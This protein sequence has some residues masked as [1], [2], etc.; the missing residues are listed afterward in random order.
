[1]DG[2]RRKNPDRPREAQHRAWSRE[3]IQRARR[4]SL[5]PILKKRGYPL[6]EKTDDNFLVTDH[7]DLVVKDFYWIW[8]SRELKG[9][10]IDFFM[11]IEG[12]SFDQT[13][14]ILCEACGED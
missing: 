4:T 7:A 14:E 10:A 6:R 5:A 3:Q 8:N 11:F 1:M 9:N 2:F 12:L 13:M